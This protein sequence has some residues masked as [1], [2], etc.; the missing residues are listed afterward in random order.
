M[1]SNQQK[2]WN[3]PNVQQQRSSFDRS[4]GHKTTFDVDNLIP[5][6]VDE[7]IPGDTLNL[8][9]SAFMRMATPI[10]PIMDNMKATIH[11]FFCPLR[12]IWDNAEQFFGEDLVGGDGNA[13]VKPFR[14]TNALA[15]SQPNTLEDYMG[16]PP[17]V[18]DLEYDE[19]P[20]RAYYEIYNQWYRDQNLQELFPIDKGDLPNDWSTIPGFD[21]APQLL[22]RNKA[23][24]YFTSSL[25][26]PQKGPDISIP[27]IDPTS[28]YLAENKELWQSEN[29]TEL[30]QIASAQS[31]QYLTSN[32]L[33]NDQFVVPN[34]NAWNDQSGT[35]NQLRI[36]FAIQKYF[37]KDARGGTRYPEVIRSHFGVTSPDARLQRP[38][39]LGRNT[40]NINVTPVAT[41]FES[42][43]PEATTGRTV[44]DLGAM[45]TAQT[46]GQQAF[47]ASFVEHGYVMGIMSVTADLTY[48]QGL[49]RKF[50]RRNRFNYYWPSFQ[51]IGE[52]AVSTQE[53]WAG[54]L[55][56]PQDSSEAFGYQERYA[57]Y[58][59]E[60]SR[61]SG[62]FRS[63]VQNPLDAWHLSQRFDEKPLLNDQ[64][65]QSN[66]PIDRVLAV[67]DEPDFIADMYFHAKWV[68]P[69]A[70]YG[71]PGNIDRF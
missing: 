33:S 52:Q 26:W 6:M 28:T 51:G 60:P 23:H 14:S 64:F 36:S 35:I 65:I 58:R 38:E 30:G 57:E 66:T 19:L 54:D 55:T 62:T 22:K 24:D 46:S 39:Y 67:Q 5:V 32:T 49:H 69:M 10:Y 27:I 4:H 50:T 37:E 70:M 45:G 13:P 63:T 1:K 20:F 61:I 44:G 56:G 17:S 71:I 12:L 18:S 15:G 11:W 59:F 25:P 48:Q 42:V 8:S 68:R 31:Q 21:Q 9:T 43:D 53:I 34:P 40:M 2:V 3:A 41:T 29:G 47:V 16:I 7:V